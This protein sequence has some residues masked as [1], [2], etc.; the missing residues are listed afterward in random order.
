MRGALMVASRAR[1][2]MLQRPMITFEIG[3]PTGVEQRALWRSHLGEVGAGLNG[4][5]DLL[6]GQFDL[7]AGAIR[8][9]SAEALQKECAEADFSKTLRDICRSQ[10]RPRLDGLA[11]RITPV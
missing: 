5:I 1:R 8:A 3:K 10:A 6:G 11:Q 2:R 9:A 7:A 4:E